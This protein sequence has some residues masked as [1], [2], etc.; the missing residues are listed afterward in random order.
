MVI[1]A[2]AFRGWLFW[3]RYYLWISCNG[4]KELLL[5]PSCCATRMV[6][7]LINCCFIA[8]LPEFFGLISWCFS[9]F[10]KYS[11]KHLFIGGNVVIWAFRLN[12]E[13]FYGIV[14]WWQFFLYIWLTGD[15][16]CV[17]FATSPLSPSV[18]LKAQS[19]AISWVLVFREFDGFYASHL[20]RC[21]LE[22]CDLSFPWFFSFWIK[23][24]NISKIKKSFNYKWLS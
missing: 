2:L 22:V 15:E 9:D 21:W 12:K 10:L 6:R 20:W 19:L 16:I 14:V 1:Q 11:I 24:V 4:R 3:R 23:L 13:L 5:M 8:P 18:A 17:V 7:I